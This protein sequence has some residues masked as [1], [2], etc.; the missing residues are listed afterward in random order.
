MQKRHGTYD[1]DCIMKDAVAAG[2][3]DGAKLL[4]GEG[5]GGG[6]WRSW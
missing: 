1:D 4:R 2:G 6:R 3:L 5:R